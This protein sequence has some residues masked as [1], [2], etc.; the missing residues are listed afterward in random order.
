MGRPKLLCVTSLFMK[1]LTGENFVKFLQRSKSHCNP[2]KIVMGNE[3]G[4]LDSTIAALVYGYFLSSLSSE[5]NEPD[6]IRVPVLNY[7]LNDFTLRP[8]SVAT[9][10]QADVTP[11]YLT[12]I[13]QI[14]LKSDTL[15]QVTLVDHNRLSSSQQFLAPLV[16][17][18]VDHH[19]DETAK[20]PNLKQSNI[21]TVGSACSLIAES[22]LSSQFEIDSTIAR[23]LLSPILSDTLNLT[24][25]SSGRTTDKDV[26]IATQLAGCVDTSLPVQDTFKS[27]YDFTETAKFD[28]SSISSF[29]LLRK[30][31]KQFSITSENRTQLVIGIS[32][33]PISFQVW[34]Q[35]ESNLR[36]HF[37][38]FRKTRGLNGLFVMLLHTTDDVFHR[39]LACYSPD[40]V[41]YDE[42]VKFIHSF[43]LNPVPLELPNQEKQPD[44]SF[45]EASTVYSRK[46]YSP[47]MCSY[48][49]KN[50]TSKH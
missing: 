28:T 30:D 38:E 2:S 48:F 32:A 24:R 33:I 9:L 10:K 27:V 31:Y 18:V 3:S 15:V 39:E 16:T 14:N 45:Y 46:K 12:F 36:T 20:L 8:E 43:D 37:E 29:D 6:D 11:E 49:S 25:D 17:E 7:A 22:I 4:D 26:Q 34:D 44:V 42:M 5:T 13:D 23:L 47:L 40:P 41:M 19:L 21:Q 35:R 50:L 1:R